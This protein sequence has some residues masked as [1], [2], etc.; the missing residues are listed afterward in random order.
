[1][2]RR[3]S[4]LSLLPTKVAYGIRRSRP[5][6]EG[7]SL[8][9][10]AS[11]GVALAVG[12]VGTLVLARV[13]G[14]DG[15]GGLSLLQATSSLAATLCLFGTPTLIVRRRLLG[16]VRGI[17]FPA[18]PIAAALGLLGSL[19]IGAGLLWLSP[20]TLSQGGVTEIA[21]AAAAVNAALLVGRE[22]FAAYLQS[23][24]RFQRLA[25][26]R[27]AWAVAPLG[28]ILLIL[29][30][31]DGAST[32]FAAVV[33]ANAAMSFLLVPLLRRFFRERELKYRRIRVSPRAR[34][35]EHLRLWRTA[36]SHPDVRAAFG[37]HVALTLLLFVYRLDILLLGALS[38][39][40]AVGLY[41][42]AFVL[43]ELPWLIANGY[44]VTLLPRLLTRSPEEKRNLYQQA[45]F[46][47]MAWAVLVVACIALI[48]QPALDL[49]LGSSFQ[50]S[51]T[52]F[53]LLAPG[54][55]AFVPFKLLATR[56]IAAGSPWRLSGVCATLVIANVLLNVLLVPRFGANGCA[57]AASVTYLLAAAFY[58]PLGRQ[59]KVI[60]G[61]PDG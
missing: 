10:S 21:L 16:P 43:A 19:L 32:V 9:I 8:A 1:M 59:T 54:I 41:A 22:G 60:E 34:L 56:L 25:A 38:T 14:P 46:R 24:H 28:A 39:A 47:S 13:L 6:R 18:V 26:W 4:A 12:A 30:W 11:Q 2:V 40:T 7:G 37:S 17:A 51:Y 57:A 61:W 15:R 55:L 5:G 58:I 33:A 27:I 45:L 23:E 49:L 35:S 52:A 36:A 50:G 42:V 31:Q 53:L 20:S 3:N 29:P 44:A 48:G